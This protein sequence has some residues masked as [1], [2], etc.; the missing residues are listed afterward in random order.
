MAQNFNYYNLVGDNGYGLFTSWD[1]LQEAALKLKGSLFFRGYLTA[2]EAYNGILK[3]V[4][5]RWKIRQVGVIDLSALM[6]K[7]LVLLDNTE[8]VVEDQDAP[9]TVGSIY[10]KRAKTGGRVC[11]KKCDS[12]DEILDEE[13]IAQEPVEQTSTDK[14]E[15]EEMYQLFKSWYKNKKKEAGE[16]SEI[17]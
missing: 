14:Q 2:R 3:N 13:D 4:M 9:S 17:K 11:M 10:R 1:D 15:E 5:F 6:K 16:K 12:L 8:E 7:Q